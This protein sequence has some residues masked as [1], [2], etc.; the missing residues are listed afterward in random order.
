MDERWARH[1]ILLSIFVVL[2]QSSKLYWMFLVLSLLLLIG[3]FLDIFVAQECGDITTHGVTSL[4]NCIAIETLLLRH[5]VSLLLLLLLLNFT[6]LLI[7]ASWMALEVTSRQFWGFRGFTWHIVCITHKNDE[8]WILISPWCLNIW[9]CISLIVA[10]VSFERL[11]LHI[12]CLCQF[13]F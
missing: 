13:W 11:K 4:F 7:N 5:N 1:V 3:L 2:L 9:S 8:Q 6:C 12:C 10:H